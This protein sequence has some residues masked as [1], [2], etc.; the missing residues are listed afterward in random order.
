MKIAPRIISIFLPLFLAPMVFLTV[1][2]TTEA[3]RGITTVAVSF[4]RF[5]ASDLVRFAQ[6]Q[7]ALLAANDLSDKPE[8]VDAAKTAVAHYAAGL[9]GDP[10]DLIVAFDKSGKTDFS[11]AKVELSPPEERALTSLIDAGKPGW[12]HVSMGGVP[13][14][15]ELSFFA[16]FGW[17][18]FVTVDR[19][20]F[21]RPVDRITLTSAL[22][23]GVTLVAVLALVVLFSS[24]LTR[25]L[26]QIVAAM[27]DI[28]RTGDLHKRVEVPY[29][30][31]VGE[32]GDS[33]NAMT[34][35]LGQA[36]GEIK[37]YALKAAIAQKREMKIRNVFQK[38]VP[39]Q[40]IDQFFASPESMLVGEDRTLAV[41]FS[42]IRGFTE[43]SETMSSRDIVESLNN[44][45]G[46]M[47]EAVMRHQGLVDK[48]IGDAVMA[49]FGAPADDAQSAYHSA[50]AALDMLDEL[51]Q[52]NVWQTERARP[53]I[54]IGIGI[55]Y[56]AVTIGNIGSEAKMDY[57]VVGD[58]VN[59]A[60]RLEGL[61]KVYK[62]PILVS[63]SIWRFVHDTLPCRLADRVQVKG[64]KRGLAV[65]AVRKELTENERQ[66]WTLHERGMEHYYDREFREALRYFTEIQ[67][68]IPED[69]I[70][71]IFAE[72]SRR[73]IENPPAPDWSG[74]V[75]YSQK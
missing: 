23:A 16:P 27:R 26:N 68:I 72:R 25:P 15:G 19:E 7:N 59:V 29:T 41:L 34:G 14:V 5:K 37:S 51:A 53:P 30:D 8:F 40:V 10:S 67:K 69:P 22:T 44:Y 71:S 35:A 6:G 63:E 74:V 55:N 2:S 13:R 49:F 1:I 3:R 46:R 52:F 45:F 54:R 57:T 12:V 70:A 66:A 20:A 11:T 38:Y 39:K 56:G 28:V 48:Y 31:E 64:R 18:L 60:S 61:T 32:L 33:F 24:L 9:V 43:L 58:M 36:Y 62:E 47:V 4:L 21:Y 73:Y 17:A 75:A 42:D 65:Y 50:V